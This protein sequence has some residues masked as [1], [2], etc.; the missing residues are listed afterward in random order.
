[1][2]KSPSRPPQ[3]Q[4]HGVCYAV[5]VVA[6][7]GLQAHEALA[8]RVGRPLPAKGVVAIERLHVTLQPVG[9]HVGDVAPALLAAAMRAAD[10]IDLAPFEL[11]F[12]RLGTLDGSPGGLALTSGAD[13]AALRKLQRALAAGMTDAGL[14]AHV[15]SSFRPHVSLL[16]AEQYF[17]REAIA[18]IRWQ[19]DELVLIDSHLGRASHGVLA[20]WPLRSGQLGFDGW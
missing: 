17:A 4:E 8:A 20:R 19:V 16:Y 13:M 2:Q 11:V 6:P 3:V 14:G 10:G 15:R 12:D 1:M 7:A 5:Q 9:T 18:P